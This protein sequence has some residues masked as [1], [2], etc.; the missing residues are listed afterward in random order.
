MEEIPI[1]ALTV[2]T[3]NSRTGDWAIM[4]SV[5]FYLDSLNVNRFQLVYARDVPS[6][7]PIAEDNFWVASFLLDV[8]DPNRLPGVFRNNGFRVG[9][10]IQERKGD[11][12]LIFFPVRRP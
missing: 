6:L 3:N 4:T 2:M 9:E 11:N 8:E 12:W 7:L 10:I 1:Y 5:Q